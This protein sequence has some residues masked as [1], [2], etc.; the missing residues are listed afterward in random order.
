MRIASSELRGALAGSGAPGVGL[1]RFESGETR[2]SIPFNDGS[3]GCACPNSRVSAVMVSGVAW[4]DAAYTF[5]NAEQ[6][7]PIDGLL[8]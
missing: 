3:R 4:A 7:L 2:T 1:V 8:G 6:L 5:Y